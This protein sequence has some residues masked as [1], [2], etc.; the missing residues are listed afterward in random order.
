MGQQMRVYFDNSKDRCRPHL[1]SP[2]TDEEIA[3]QLSRNN[4]NCPLNRI[5]V[6]PANEGNFRILHRFATA[7][8][9]NPT[10]SCKGFNFGIYSP[11]GQGKTFVVKRWAETIGIPFVFVQSSSLKSTYHLFEQIQKECEKRACPIVPHKTEKADFVL[12]PMIVFFDEAHEISSDLQRGG[13]LNPLEPDDGHMH[14]VEPGVRGETVSVNCGAVCWIAATTDPADLFDAFRSR[15]MNKIEWT[16]AGPDE[17]PG[18]IRAGLLEKLR[19]GEVRSIPPESICK[20]IA[21]Y[22]KVPRLAIHGLGLQVCLEKES[23]PSST[24]EECCKTVASDL[25]IDE[26]GF[27]KKQIMILKALGNRPLAKGR[28]G[29]ICNCRAA[30]VEQMELPGLM[31]YTD[32]GPYCLTVSGKGMCITQAGISQLEKR[33]IPHNGRKVTVE[34]FESKR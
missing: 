9:K 28:L 13:L 33:G 20:R 21:H 4:A 12:P 7:A 24:W 18:I 26:W 10:R 1:P 29:D 31:Q 8:Y 2:P 30:Q 15:F 17:L 19:Q 27:S 6:S 25:G 32:G 34:Y 22:Q 3:V 23:M 14:V 11:P 5:I 16:P